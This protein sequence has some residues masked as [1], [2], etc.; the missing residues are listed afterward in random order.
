MN[1]SGNIIFIFGVISGIGFVFVLCL[2]DCGNI[3]IVG[4]CWEDCFVVIV[5][6]YFGISIVCIDMVDVDSIDIVVWI[7]FFVYFDLNVVIVMVGIMCVEDWI[8]WEGFFVM[9]EEIVV[10][11]ILGLICFIGVFIEYLWVQLDV[12]IMIVLLGFVFVLLC[13]ILMYNVSKVVI[14]M[15]S[16]LLWFQ[17]VGMSVL[18]LEFELFVVC[19]VFMLGY[20]EN[21]FVM[22]F[23]EFVDEVIFLFE[24]QLDVIEI[25]V[26]WVK[27][28]W[29][30]EVCGDYDIVVV[31]L[32]WIDLYMC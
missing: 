19:I 8:M 3:V 31:I 29:Y 6:E 5:V 11:N 7:V 15:L 10:I 28:L 32:N 26:E 9:V 16:E 21:E 30:G 25:Q 2:Y 14:Y 27:F 4:G 24:N 12:M 20:E 1:I 17:F 22:L 18:V 23:D 13:V